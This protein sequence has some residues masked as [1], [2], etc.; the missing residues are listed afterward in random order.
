MGLAWGINTNC[1]FIAF[2]AQFCLLYGILL[3]GKSLLQWSLYFLRRPQNF[4]KS[5]PYFWLALHRTKVRGRCCKILWPSQNIWTLKITA[6]KLLNLQPFFFWK[7]VRG[8]NGILLQNCSDLLWEK[9]V[10][11]IEQIFWNTRLKAENF[12][13]FWNH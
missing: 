6:P 8:T 11:V 9:I 1:G 3:T 4:A 2:F 10:L 5:S 12:Q 13:K 7:F